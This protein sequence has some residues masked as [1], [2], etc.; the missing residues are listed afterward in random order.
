[1][2]VEIVAS[3]YLEVFQDRGLSRGQG[4]NPVHDCFSKIQPQDHKM[5]CP[6]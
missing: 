1:M 3:H 6:G 2:W 5:T 4:Q